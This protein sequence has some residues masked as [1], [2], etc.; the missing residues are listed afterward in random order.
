[1]SMDLQAFIN[2]FLRDLRRGEHFDVADY[3]FKMRHL[4][5][6]NKVWLTFDM[7]RRAQTFE[8]M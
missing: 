1:M 2:K 4:K 5:E 6:L 7:Y 3:I 8:K